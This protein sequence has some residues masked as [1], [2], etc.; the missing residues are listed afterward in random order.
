[1]SRPQERT[2]YQPPPRRKQYSILFLG[3]S[4]TGK[5]SMRN[6][7]IYNEMQQSMTFD[8]TLEDSHRKPMTIDSEE[9]IVDIMETDSAQAA[10]TLEH[11]IRGCDGVI[12]MYSICSPESF[13]VLESLWTTVKRV[14]V[15]EK[16]GVYVD[17]VGTMSDIWEKRSVKTED[18][19]ALAERLNCGFS[20]CSAKEGENCEGLVENLIRKIVVGREQE[21]IL[22]DARRKKEDDEMEVREK[23]KNGVVKRVLK[24]CAELMTM[25]T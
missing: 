5:A 24:R 16:K 21:R 3:N 9:C 23:K 22:R 2:S 12:L 25:G 10:H 6:R 14:K 19:K 20:E 18:G 17:I 7:I 15:P 13:G 8:P 1:M 4:G 11:Y